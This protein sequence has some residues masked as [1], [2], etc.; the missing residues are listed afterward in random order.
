MRL[1][2][3]C[4]H[5]ADGPAHSAP[6]LPP[7]FSCPLARAAS[8]RPPPPAPNQASSY[9]QPSLGAVFLS[10]SWPT[11]LT[12]TVT[13]AGFPVGSWEDEFSGLWASGGRRFVVPGP[14]S[15]Q[16]GPHCTARGS[17]SCHTPTPCPPFSPFPRLGLHGMT[18]GGCSAP[19][20]V[21][22]SPCISGPLSPA[23]PSTSPGALLLLPTALAEML[24]LGY[25]ALMQ[26]PQA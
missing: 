20:R 8:A 4:E 10:W 1:Q 2:G 13:Q 23:L 24:P 11:L 3:L 22:A 25:Y 17:A 9:S 7:G 21:S 16:E 26:T 6:L 19:H 14:V 15:P 12:R 5:R 18:Q